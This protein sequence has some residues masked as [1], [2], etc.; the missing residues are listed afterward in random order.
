MGTFSVTDRGN[1]KTCR[2]LWDHTS[3]SRQGLAHP[4]PAK[5]LILGSLVHYALAD[6]IS[7][8]SLDPVERFLAHYAGAEKEIRHRYELHNDSE[9]DDEEFRKSYGEE[10]GELGEAMIRNYRD[11]YERP[12]P[13]GWELI[14]AE[15]TVTIEVPGTWQYRRKQ[16]MEPHKLEGTFDALAVD[17]RGRIFVV[18]HKT[19]KSKPSQLELNMND[20]FLA[21][22]WLGQKAIG[23]PLEG[24]LYNGL[25][26]RADIIDGRT[27]KEGMPRESGKPGKHADGTPYTQADL[28]FRTFVP[29]PREE[30]ANFGGRLA[31]ELNEMGNR[32]AIYLNRNWY[33]CMNC[34][35]EEMCISKTRGEDYQYLLD[36]FVPRV[37]TPAWREEI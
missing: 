21:Y 9:M 12:L 32:P 22:T 35:I 13:K 6:W 19:Y 36:E 17:P 27:V 18:D 8:P 7:N 10:V 34:A 30:L 33:S 31:I 11:Y 14:A 29:H 25:W 1:F 20:Q 3:L 28:F 37:K 26:K 24:V 5:P 23:K 4:M 15:Q 16:F 2:E